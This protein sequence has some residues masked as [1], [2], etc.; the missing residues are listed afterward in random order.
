MAPAGAAAAALAL[1]AAVCFLLVAPAPARRPADLPP[2]AAVLLPEPVDYREA[3]ADAEPL[4]PPKPVA[5]ADAAALAV[6]EEEEERG[7]ARP[8]ASLLCLVFR[9]DD[10]DEANAVAVRRS[11]GGA[12]DGG[13][14]PRAAWKGEGDESDSDSDSDCDSDSDDDDDEGGE[15]GIVGWFWSLAHRF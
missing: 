11:G 13:W 1:A 5:D 10:G 14:W 8:R 12:Q 15:G 3:A 9:C 4:L 7:P 6:P 2:Q